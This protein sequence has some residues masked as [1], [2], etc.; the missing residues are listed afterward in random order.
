[1]AL[2]PKD[3]TV[4]RGTEKIQYLRGVEIEREKSNLTV[5]LSK[6]N[7][8]GIYTVQA[9]LTSK[10][11]TETAEDK[12]A[13]KMLGELMLQAIKDGAQWRDKWHKLN[14]DQ[15]QIEMFD[16]GSG[17][18]DTNDGVIKTGFEQ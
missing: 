14:S 16:A 10:Q 15:N 6:N 17:S 9:Q 2:K 8:K 7:K 12:Q 11:I 3:Y 1:M 4:Q 5:V 18:S 13:V